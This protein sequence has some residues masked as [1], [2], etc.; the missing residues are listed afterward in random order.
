MKINHKTYCPYCGR[1]QKTGFV[2]KI[3]GRK[4]CTHCGFTFNAADLE[5]APAPVKK[6]RRNGERLCIY[7][8]EPHKVTLKERLARKCSCA[9]CGNSFGI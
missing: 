3:R 6:E 7:C 2:A 9:S 1:Q 8:G 4:V 5:A